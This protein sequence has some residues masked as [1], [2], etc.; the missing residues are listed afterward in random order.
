MSNESNAERLFAWMIRTYG[1]TKVYSSYNIHGEKPSER[2]AVLANVIDDWDAQIERFNGPTLK[3]AIQA[4][5]D[6]GKG[7][8]PSL[9]EFVALCRDF[10]RP[11]ASTRPILSAPR[12]KKPES[13]NLG[14]LINRTQTDHLRWARKLGSLTAARYLTSPRCQ[15]DP[16]LRDILA[17]HAANDFDGLG[18]EVANYLRMKWSAICEKAA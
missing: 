2:D 5:I 18:T 8:P 6:G 17:A 4:L 12:Q 9:P 13:V 7:W 1:L 3:R 16:R 11:E 15:D 10:N 14:S